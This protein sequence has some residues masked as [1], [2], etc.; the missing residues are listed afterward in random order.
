MK[1]LALVLAAALLAMPALPH[2][3]A[4]ATAGMSEPEAL[5]RGIYDQYSADGNPSDPYD[6]DFSPQL[7]K[8]W[9]A[10]EDGA[11]DDDQ[12][13][14]DFDVFLDAQDT[15]TVTNLATALHPAGADKAMVDVTFS[16]FGEKKS[17][18][19]AMVKTADGWKIDN[20][21]WGAGRPDLRATLDD[22]LKK[23][24]SPH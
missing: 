6:D 11:G 23:Q 13:G 12:N 24:Q 16:A 7:L 10:V 17:L 9:E 22:L 1:R 14:I 8:L 19:Y 18:R 5:V 15:D 20:I 2:V 21:S 3:T 4:A